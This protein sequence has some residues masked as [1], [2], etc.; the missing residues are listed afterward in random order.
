MISLDRILLLQQK[1]ESAVEKISALQAEN[2]A[3]RTKCAELSQSLSHK[4]EQLSAFEKDQSKIENGI[5][6][7]LDRLNAIENTILNAADPAAAASGESAAPA[8][9]RTAPP[10]ASPHTGA[11]AA[12]APNGEF[13]IF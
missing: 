10:P 9:A 4:S 5:L 7:A 12:P 6:K 13:D 3:L 1:V 2:D 8:K 11:D